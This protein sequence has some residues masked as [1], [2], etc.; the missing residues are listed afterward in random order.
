MD[1]GYDS[2]PPGPD[3]HPEGPT[4]PAGAG[5]S[6]RSRSASSIH[7]K[8]PKV[9]VLRHLFSESPSDR[10]SEEVEVDITDYNKRYSGAPR[11]L[12]VRGLTAVGGLVCLFCFRVALC[13]VG[14]VLSFSTHALDTVSPSSPS[15]PLE[16]GRSLWGLL[17]VLDDLV[18]VVLLLICVINI[19]QQ[20][21]PERRRRTASVLATR[22][23]L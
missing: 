22:G 8:R 14:T 18:A 1:R 20:M 11:K 17:G 15:A 2:S 9:S 5:A 4:G 12:L 19:H 21:E 3:H 16:T 23:V 6:I 10:R 13:C 7:T